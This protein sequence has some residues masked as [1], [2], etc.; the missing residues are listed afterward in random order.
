[1]A[2]EEG[3]HVAREEELGFLDSFELPTA[4]LKLAGIRGARLGPRKMLPF[5]QIQLADERGAAGWT[6]I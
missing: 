3:A 4:P 5:E 2:C 1:V 6:P